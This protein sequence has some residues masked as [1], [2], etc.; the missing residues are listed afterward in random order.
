MPDTTASSR[1]NVLVHISRLHKFDGSSTDFFCQ[2]AGL[3]RHGYTVHVH[4]R[5]APSDCQEP[6][7]SFEDALALAADP[8]TIII[9][10]FCGFDR[11]LHALR[12]AAKGYFIIRYQNVTPPKWFLPYSFKGYAHALLGRMQMHFFVKRQQLDLLMP[13]SQ[14]SANELCRNISEHKRP[15][16][17]V[18]PVQS[19]YVMFQKKTAAAVAPHKKTKTALYVSRLLPHK[20]LTHL[21]KLLDAWKV[22]DSAR[23][24]VELKIT[25]AGKL[26]AEYASFLNRIRQDAER[27]NVLTQLTFHTDIS[28]ADLIALYHNA[29]VYLCPSEHEGFGIPVVDAQS[30]GL[31][32]VALDMGA[33]AETVGDGAA[34][35]EADPIDYVRFAN[36]VEKVL[37]D[38][39]MRLRLIDAG[40]KNVE[41]F[42]T[43]RVT[44]QLLDVLRTRKHPST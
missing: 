20:G 22:T 32:V 24:G 43:E 40:H 8:A 10:T 13:A 31:P 19:D 25:I 11:Q 28:Q 23:S 2:L 37:T 17:C 34:I 29:D 18:V 42:A 1:T 15:P 41:R 14:F 26:S 39:D 44:A 4:S 33:T 27:R 35:I 7:V 36:T 6:L 30:A 16:V 9:F 5:S 3:R 21:V 38:D 12:K